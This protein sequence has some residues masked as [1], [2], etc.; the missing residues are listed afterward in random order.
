MESKQSISDYGS[1][2]CTCASDEKY[3]ELWSKRT[4]V[5]RMAKM[6]NVSIKSYGYLFSQDKG[7][8]E[9]AHLRFS[10]QLDEIKGPSLHRV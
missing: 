3:S 1:C 9:M 5:C 8:V 2:A 10:C 7:N 4:S 6:A